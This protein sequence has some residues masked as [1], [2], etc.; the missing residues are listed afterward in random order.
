MAAAQVI[1]LWIV[2]AALVV[3]GMPGSYFAGHWIGHRDGVADERIEAKAR[4]GDAVVAGIEAANELAALDQQKAVAAERERGKARLAAATRNRE[5]HESIRTEVVYRDLDCRIPDADI[6]RVNRAL[7]GAAEAGTQPAGRGD[8]GM[9]GA[10][11]AAKR[12]PGR[13]D[14]Q[15]GGDGG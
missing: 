1:N 11:P 2:I 10:G 3:V 14:A 7:A 6:V 4:E 13:R 12:E 8:G 15:A 5:I 9:S